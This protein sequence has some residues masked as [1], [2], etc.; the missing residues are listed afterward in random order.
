MIIIFLQRNETEIPDTHHEETEKGCE[1][2]ITL[3][4]YSV[5]RMTV[6]LAFV[7]LFL[8]GSSIDIGGLLHGLKPH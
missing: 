1:V 3:L 5:R 4:Q 8:A 7:I 2:M 6:R